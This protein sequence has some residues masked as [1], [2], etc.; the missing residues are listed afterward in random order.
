M[1]PR[2]ILDGIPEDFDPQ[3]DIAIGPWCFQDA[4]TV[5]P[6][7][8]QLD[9]INPFSTPEEMEEASQYA[10]ALYESLVPDLAVKFNKIHGTDFSDFSWRHL[11]MGWYVMLIQVSC[12]RFRHIEYFIENHKEQAFQVKLAPEDITWDLPISHR[13]SQLTSRHDF[14]YWLSSVIIRKLAP[15]HWVLEDDNSFQ[16]VEEK[17]TDTP[18]PPAPLTLKEKIRD[19]VLS[20]IE[21][22]RFCFAYGTTW[23][24]QLFFFLFLE[25][26]PAKKK[27]SAND[28]Y[29]PIID[30]FDPKAYFSGPYLDVLDFLVKNTIPR[31]YADPS[32]FKKNLSI[33]S[34]VKYKAGKIRV[35][36]PDVFKEVEK[37]KTVLAMESGE[38]IVA[39][40]HG[41]FYGTVSCASV[42][43]MAEYAHHAFF[44]WG[45]NNHIYKGKYIPLPAPLPYRM[46]K[47]RSNAI[48]N[49]RPSSLL[50]VDNIMNLRSA[51]LSGQPMPAD[52]VKR[53]HHKKDFLQALEPSVYQ[54]TIFRPHVHH[55]AGID[56]TAFLKKSFPDLNILTAPS[57]DPALMDCKLYVSNHYGT[58]LH[59]SLAANIPTVCYWD[60]Y[61]PLTPKA[62]E[63]FDM[64]KEQNILFDD[65]VEAAQHINAVWDDLDAWWHNPKLQA[66]RKKWCHQYART[67]PFWVLHWAKTLM[68]I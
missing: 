45:W 68:K 26:L 15:K 21:S 11:L 1:K 67:S 55:A 14:D 35:I 50:L 23:I 62:Q 34:Q 52:V 58:T 64:L 39:T 27:T 44:S 31:C 42:S 65:P 60:D 3:H 18:P 46:K 29:V 6:D 54:E 4:E 38:K 49:K 10:I 16:I 30:S 51:R 47:Q 61:P 9:F 33:A 8:D 66:T 43:H 41:S 19:Y 20:K 48:K 57:M 37:L 2:L 24:S 12:V 17:K 32:V 53:R 59:L 36:N 22:G 13:L 56:E 5:Y 28:T 25:L 7:W 63:Y 40:Q